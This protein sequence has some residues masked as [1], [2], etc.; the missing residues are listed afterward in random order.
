MITPRPLD[1]SDLDPLADL[2]HNGWREAHLEHVPEELTARRTLE[3][4]RNR[5]EGF[6]D[7]LRVA[8]APGAPLGF[9]A[10]RADELDQL[11]VAPEARGSGLATTLL[12]DGEARLAERGIRRAHLLCVIQNRRAA[13]FYERQ[14]WQNM[15][16]SHEA[17]QTEDGP[18]RFDLLRFEKDL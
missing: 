17:V 10:I 8:G 11:F 3:S 6:G 9:C 18:F 1:A 15:G 13:K 7:G 16:V 5:L 2:W 12:A 14:G 4:F